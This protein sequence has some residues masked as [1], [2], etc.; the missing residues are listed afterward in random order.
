VRARLLEPGF[1]HLRITQFSETTAVDL[2]RELA[3]LARK[4]P[5]SGVVLDL[6]N[7]T[8]GVLE[9]AIDVTDLFVEQGRIVSAEGR[10]IDARF[11]RDARPGDMLGGAP[12][13]VLV[14]GGTASA[15]E[16]VAGALQ[17]HRRGVVMGERTF[18][19]GSVQTIMPL[20]GGTALKLTT[21]R[22]YTPNGRSIQAAGIVPDV[23]LVAMQPSAAVS[24]LAPTREADLARHLDNGQGAAA[25]EDADG[26][27]AAQ[28][29]MLWQALNALKVA[30]L[31]RAKSP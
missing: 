19:K 9:S 11:H 18:G 3:A 4:Q 2:E 31:A 17:D 13:V 7:N 29:P 23:P 21:A 28:D 8:G 30:R 24:E 26:K 20:E 27:L 25:A 16:I 10:A 6:R 12:L 15:A 14:N 1:A 5:L 22:Y